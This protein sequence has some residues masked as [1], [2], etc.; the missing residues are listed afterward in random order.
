MAVNSLGRV[1]SL[2]SQRFFLAPC[3][4][5]VQV[6]GGAGV[7]CQSEYCL[8]ESGGV[9]NGSRGE[10]S[11][12]VTLHSCPHRRKKAQQRQQRARCEVC[13][14]AS[15]GAVAPE[16]FSAVDHLTGRMHSIRLCSRHAPRAEALRH[17][18]NWRQ[19]MDEVGKRDRPLFASGRK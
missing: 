3:C 18:A 15:A 17:V 11:S 9:A 12:G 1:V 4:C 10:L 13:K 16:V 8:A 5:T 19:L 6:Y 7:E 2:R 14:T